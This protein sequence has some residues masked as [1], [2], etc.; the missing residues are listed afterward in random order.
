MR[1]TRQI[2]TTSDALRPGV[3]AVDASAAASVYSLRW[4]RVAR[5][6]DR[7]AAL[8]ALVEPKVFHPGVFARFIECHR[9]VAA[10]Y[11]AAE[12]LRSVVDVAQ[13]AE[14]QPG[15]AS[16]KRRTGPTTAR[17][18]CEKHRSCRARRGR[19]RPWREARGCR[20]SVANQLFACSAG[21]STI[22]SDGNSAD[23]KPNSTNNNVPASAASET[24][25]RIW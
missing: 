24:V 8:G 1:H 25:N 10:A 6:Q 16:A 15:I 11:R 5:T 13:L 12:G 9:A 21:T 4:R 20:R 7:W 23:E 18:S 14:M 17:R 2:V 22:C 3:G 19:D